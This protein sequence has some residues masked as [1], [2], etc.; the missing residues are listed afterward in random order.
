MKAEFVVD[1]FGEVWFMFADD[2]F[3]RPGGVGQ[4]NSFWRTQAAFN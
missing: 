1:D 3:A 2:I 4:R